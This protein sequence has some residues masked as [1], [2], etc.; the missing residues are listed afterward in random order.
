MNQTVRCGD[1]AEFNCTL[2]DCNS[3][4]RLYVNHTNDHVATEVLHNPGDLPLVGCNNNASECGV[5]HSFSACDTNHSLHSATFWII[6]TN[7][8][9]DL[10]N[11][12][13]CKINDGKNVTLS[14]GGHLILDARCDNDIIT[15]NNEA[16]MTGTENS[17]QYYITATTRNTGVN[18]F[19]S[20]LSLLL[21]SFLISALV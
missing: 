11:Y 10:I 3:Q 16:T 4:L 17:S 5:S 8:T 21:S 7:N 18:H 13:F 6:I 12:V 20:P 9:Q 15:E 19:I 1:R 2:G 14:K